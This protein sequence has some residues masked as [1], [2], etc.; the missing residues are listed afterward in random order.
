VSETILDEAARLTG[1]DRNKSYGHP[2]D[3]HT[4]TA[5]FW[6]GWLTRKYGVTVKLDAEDVCWMN[7]LQKISREANAP[8]RDT[9]V[10]VAGYA[11]NVEMVQDE[12]YIRQLASETFGPLGE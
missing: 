6:T 12:R 9:V 7:I 2:L 5:D 11:R 4:V 10:D 8:K 1:G 3:N